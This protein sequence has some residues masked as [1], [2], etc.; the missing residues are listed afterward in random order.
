MKR[1]PLPI[2]ASLAT[3]LL[4][5]METARAQSPT[6]AGL[7]AAGSSAG[8][9]TGTTVETV[10]AII[11]NGVLGIAGLIF[12]VMIV[13]GGVQY[14]LSQGDAGLVKKAKGTLTWSVIG[15]VI[16]VAAY[17]LTTFLFTSLATI[18]GS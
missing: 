7:A 16:I 1:L 13:W 10:I 17:A 3:P 12:I 18:L 5:L 4:F 2:I 11:I 6:Q 9:G 8:Y 14:F 15:L